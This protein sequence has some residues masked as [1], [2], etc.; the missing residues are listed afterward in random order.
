MTD[1]QL[2]RCQSE[3]SEGS[4]NKYT[5]TCQC[6]NFDTCEEDFATWSVSHFEVHQGNRFSTSTKLVEAVSTHPRG[7][8]K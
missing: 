2:G 4:V 5:N 6:Q 3:E 1:S 7:L 8:P